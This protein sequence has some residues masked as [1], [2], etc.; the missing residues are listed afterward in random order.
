[1][2]T[3]HLKLQI[4]LFIFILLPIIVIINIIGLLALRLS[5]FFKILLSI[6]IVNQPP[7]KFD[8]IFLIFLLLIMILEDHINL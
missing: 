8:V 4:L 3:I 5:Q 6:L 7:I 1:M 2:F